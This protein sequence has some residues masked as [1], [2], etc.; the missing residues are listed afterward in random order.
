MSK[1]VKLGQIFQKLKYASRHTLTWIP[2]VY[3]LKLI[4]KWQEIVF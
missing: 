3:K 2:W 1:N 4:N